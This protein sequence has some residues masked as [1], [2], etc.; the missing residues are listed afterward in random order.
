[1]VKIT[2][3]ILVKSVDEDTIV[4]IQSKGDYD[5]RE[6]LKIPNKLDLLFCVSADKFFSILSEKVTEIIQNPTTVTLKTESGEYTLPIFRERGV[7]V[8]E[9]EVNLPNSQ[10]KESWEDDFS[11]KLINTKV[12]SYINPNYLLVMIGPDFL[13]RSIN[14]V[15]EKYGSGKGLFSIMPPQY[16]LLQKMG[17]VKLNLFET[18]ELQ[19]IGEG[20]ELRVKKTAIVPNLSNL[21]NEVC[22][23][24]P[25]V[26]MDLSKVKLK[27]MDKFILERVYLEIKTGAVSFIS[28]SARK[29]IEVPDLVVEE[30]FDIMVNAKDLKYLFGKLSIYK[31]NFKGTQTYSLVS[32]DKN[33]TTFIV[34]YP[35][36]KTRVW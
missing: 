12:G 11:D 2:P 4:I 8:S 20:S 31:C 30:S 36:P 26:T 3:N 24:L 19:V 21:E 25:I 14:N 6:F 18:G 33:K 32:R 34:T 9:P 23:G 29:T 15:A 16:V 27:T 10:I 1:M 13:C 35:S 28:E 17:K 7:L 5:F 22:Q